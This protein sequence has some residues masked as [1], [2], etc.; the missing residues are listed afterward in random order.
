MTITQISANIKRLEN[1]NKDID[2]K[3]E[4]KSN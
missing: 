4:V 3:N 2:V 1:L